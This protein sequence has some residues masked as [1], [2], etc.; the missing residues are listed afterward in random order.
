LSAQDKLRRYEEFMRSHMMNPGA[1]LDLAEGQEE[2]KRELA[3][4]GLAGFGDGGFSLDE[5]LSLA[6]AAKRKAIRTHSVRN[7]RIS[8]ALHLFRHFVLKSR[9]SRET[10]SML[11]S[12][13]ERHLQLLSD[14]LSELKEEPYSLKEPEA[15][16]CEKLGAESLQPRIDSRMF[17]SAFI[18]L[19]TEKGLDWCA[20]HL[21]VGEEETRKAASSLAGMIESRGDKLAQL[22]LGKRSRRAEEFTELVKDA[23]D[24]VKKRPKKR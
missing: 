7:A 5:E 11:P 16:I 3:K 2:L 4:T 8:F 18:F 1:R 12:F 13:S 20:E 21:G 22:G 10:S 15:L 23:G 6:L 14:V 24:K 17:G 9:R 19:T